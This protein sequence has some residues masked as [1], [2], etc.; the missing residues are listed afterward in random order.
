MLLIFLCRP[1]PEADILGR[2]LRLQRK[3]LCLHRMQRKLCCCRQSCQFLQALR[4]IGPLR[5]HPPFLLCLLVLL[6]PLPLTLFG[7]RLLLGHMLHALLC[8]SIGYLFFLLCRLI[9][10]ILLQI[11]LLLAQ[12]LLFDHEL[13]L[14]LRTGLIFRCSLRNPCLRREQMRLCCR[15][16]ISRFPDCQAALRDSRPIVLIVNGTQTVKSGFFPPQLLDRKLRFLHIL[17]GL[18]Q[19][20]QIII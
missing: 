17:Q 13:P 12:R 6:P 18:R 1:L 9:G 15:Q 3:S 11:L 2:I 4:Q 5:I 14:P 8:Q 16:P 10:L 19:R 7:Q 20:T